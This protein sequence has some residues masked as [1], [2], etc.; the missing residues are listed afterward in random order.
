M[1]GRASCPDGFLPL[2]D[3]EPRA[4][5][6]LVQKGGCPGIDLGRGGARSPALYNRALNTKNFLYEQFLV[7]VL[8]LP[9][10]MRCVICSVMLPAIVGC[11]KAKVIMISWQSLSMT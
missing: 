5:P 7:C 11:V 3:G 9:W 2:A 6:A 1:S 10:R 8:P 4:P